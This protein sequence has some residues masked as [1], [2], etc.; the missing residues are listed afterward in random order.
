M[1]A[2]LWT[3]VLWSLCGT[4]VAVAQEK[5]EAAPGPEAQIAPPAE[6]SA[7]E[8]KPTEAKAPAEPT[9]DEARP[10]P[11]AQRAQEP[12]PATTEPS[13]AVEPAAP[14]AA[15]PVRA[16]AAEVEKAPPAKAAAQ[17]PFQTS[18][19]DASPEDPAGASPAWR[20]CDEAPL[21]LGDSGRARR[22][23]R[24]DS[25]NDAEGQ[26]SLGERHARAEE[27]A[28][29][30]APLFCPQGSPPRLDAGHSAGK[31]RVPGGQPGAPCRAE[32]AVVRRQ[33]LA[34]T[35]VREELPGHR[36]PRRGQA[37]G[38]GYD[39]AAGHL[40]GGEPGDRGQGPGSVAEGA[41]RGARRP[42]EEMAGLAIEGL[43]SEARERQARAAGK[44]PARR[45]DDDEED[46]ES[47]NAPPLSWTPSPPTSAAG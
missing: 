21:D 19:Q 32:G 15:E 45:D 8:E 22:I 26:G 43:S 41:A 11:S 37:L 4:G 47:G 13:K 2:V 29:A 16:E 44:D 14:S 3:A 24:S 17:A 6:A 34:E 12:A 20:A 35:V 40:P 23:P 9:P 33:R 7:A 42:G 31:D 36:V 39:R 38:R 28:R 27:D 18:W 25:T 10:A 30:R 1:R 5:T 46:G